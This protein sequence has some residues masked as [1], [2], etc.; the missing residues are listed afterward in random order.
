MNELLAHMIQV[1]GGL[2]L[3]VLIASAL[4][5]FRLQ[6]K[7]QLASLP[8]LVRQLFWVYGAYV[9]LSIV[10]L[11]TICL[12]NATELAH[13]SLLARSVCGYIAIFWGI[14]L[15]LQTRLDAVSFLTTW[16]LKTGY[17]LLTVLFASLTAVFVWAACHPAS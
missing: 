5:P 17:H 16:W 15:L 9:V 8:R 14:R 2:Q 1:A 11:G 10:A 13:G 4:V 3:S 6:W 12:V 7:V